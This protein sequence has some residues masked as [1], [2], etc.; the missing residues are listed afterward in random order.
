MDGFPV[1]GFYKDRIPN[2]SP[3]RKNLSQ[4]ENHKS[5]YTRE[6]K[7]EKRK[8]GKIIKGVAKLELHKRGIFVCV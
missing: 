8:T 4:G 1:K 2:F 3:S 5:L 6:K 7:K